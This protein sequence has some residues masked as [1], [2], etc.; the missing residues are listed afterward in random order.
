MTSYL[1][2]A[3]GYFSTGYDS[4]GSA[5]RDLLLR[6]TQAAA[7]DLITRSKFLPAAQRAPYMLT[8]LASLDAALP[9]KVEK[10]LIALFRKGYSDDAAMEK[11]IEIEAANSLIGRVVEE[12]QRSMS[13]LGASGAEKFFRD[14]GRFA[15]NLTQGAVCSGALRDLIVERVGTGSGRDAAMTAQA[16]ADALRGAAGCTA[17]SQATPATPPAPPAPTLPPPAPASIPV[18]P[19][20]V[21]G[22]V[23]IG[24]VVFAARR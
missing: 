5:P 23:L 17:Q 10:T 11:A 13:G 8:E 20:L 4:L 14:A 19:F 24:V 9:A 2:R 21:G 16:G 6:S 22:A 7:R 18:W 3:P 1:G 12:G 15:T